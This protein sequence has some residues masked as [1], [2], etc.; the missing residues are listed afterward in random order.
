[1]T[2]HATG[3]CPWWIWWLL[4]QEIVALEI[5]AVRS[6]RLTHVLRFGKGYTTE[7][8]ETVVLPSKQAAGVRSQALRNQH[9]STQVTFP[10]QNLPLCEVKTVFEP[11][12]CHHQSQKSLKS[13]CL[14]GQTPVTFRQHGEGKDTC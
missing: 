11:P 4:A 8:V 6:S 3:A 14:H 5:N 13:Q 10:L 12:S 2:I 1:M 9:K 7:H